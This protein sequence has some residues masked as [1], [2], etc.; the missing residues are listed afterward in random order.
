MIISISELEDLMEK[1]G[2][3]KRQILSACKTPKQWAELINST[4]KTRSTLSV[5]V[6]NL[7]EMGL[8]EYDKDAHTYSI[9]KKGREFL[10]LVPHIRPLPKEGK[11]P[12]ELFKVVGKGIRFGHLSIKEKVL[13]D[14]LGV[15]GL[16]LD[17]N[18]KRYYE[19]IVRA[20]R[21]SV[22]FWTPEGVEPDKDMYREVNKL[23]GVYT[24]KHKDESGKITMV[25]EFDFAAALE[26]VIR[27]E[28]DDK[29]RERL[30]KNR[31]TI[32]KQV[33]ANWHRIF[34]QM[35]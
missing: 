26:I 14:I 1:V 27:E 15:Q 31:D 7:E 9:T 5:H 20:V 17:Q 23:I 2:E 32:I 35:F 21:D 11:D 18:L 25:I 16:A 19:S 4:Q 10:Q 34:N 8:L 3:T 6:N 24:K 12:F 30:E 28:K 29:V 13:Q 33:H 22:T